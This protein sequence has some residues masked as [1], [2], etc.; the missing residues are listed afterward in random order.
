MQE[1]QETCSVPRLRRSLGDG[2]GN[3]LQYS[4]LENFM[5]IGAWWA[6]VHE[7]TKS[8]TQLSD[9]AHSTHTPLILTVTFKQT[10]LHFTE[11]PG[12]WVIDNWVLINKHKW[13]CSLTWYK[14]MLLYSMVI[15][16]EIYIYIFKL[17]LVIIVLA[18]LE[19]I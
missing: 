17:C 9:W 15:N 16:N 10:H 18:V 13:T 19:I 14:C 6:A 8:Q 1:M 3:L 2:S 4:F 7:V 12:R 11:K 5:D